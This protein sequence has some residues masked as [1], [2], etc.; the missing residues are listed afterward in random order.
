MNYRIIRHTIGQILKM[1]AAL[2]SVPFITSAVCGELSDHRVLF[3]FI[4]PAL[5]MLAL[6]YVLAGEPPEDKTFYSREGIVIVGASW[7][8]ISVLG[9]LPFLFWSA[10][11]DLYA[12]LNFIDWLFESA[13]GFSTTGATVLSGAQMAG[14]SRGL[15]MWRSLSQWIGGMG[16]LL[17][18][19]AVLPSSAGASGLFLLQNETTGFTAGKLVSKTTINAKILYIV[20]GLLTALMILALS[21]TGLSSGGTDFFNAVILS[22]GTAS[23]GGFAASAGSVGDFNV[24]VQVI[25]GIFMLL[26]G[27]NFGLYF[28]LLIGRGRS[29]LKSE[30]LRFY[31]IVTALVITVISLNLWLATDGYGSFWNALGIAAFTSVSIITT[32]SYDITVASGFSVHE[33][34]AFS[35]VLLLGLMFIGGCAG[36]TSGGF[37]CSRVIILVKSA[38]AKCKG[39]LNPNAVYTV[40]LDGKKLDDK[41]VSG[42]SNFFVLYMLIFLLG[43][44]LISLDPFVSGSGQPLLTSLS[45]V[46]SS[47]SNV[48]PGLAP[49]T[50]MAGNYAGLL[51]VSKAFL[52]IVMLVGRLEIYPMLLLLSPKTYTR[53]Y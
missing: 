36:S 11:K 24:A 34:A 22:L 27:I 48:G 20:Y 42:V 10:G 44:V 16:I 15:L 46:L 25:V 17:F 33:W 4:V 41:T 2:L 40:K 5:I 3:A 52:S 19:L 50:G 45:S 6:G 37:K 43:S 51:P 1:I 29:V 12:Q 18:A 21:L 7:V 23:T 8:V 32:T 30:E 35:Q 13:S 38:Y 47:I 31:L 14:M 28:M 53:K 49:E 39:I 9:A 26:F